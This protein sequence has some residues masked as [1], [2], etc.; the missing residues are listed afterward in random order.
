[1]CFFPLLPYKLL[2]DSRRTVE[3]PAPISEFQIGGGG[4]VSAANHD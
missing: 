3:P 4:Q 1:M 2:R